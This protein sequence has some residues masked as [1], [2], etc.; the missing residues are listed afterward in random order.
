MYVCMLVSNL[1]YRQNMTIL[2]IIIRVL[3]QKRTIDES[4]NTCRT[5]IFRASYEQI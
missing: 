5:K 2:I 1:Y 3:K 4:V